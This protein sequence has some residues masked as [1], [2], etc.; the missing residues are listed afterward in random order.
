VLGLG[1]LRLLSRVNGKSRA[2]RAVVG[3]VF[4]LPGESDK[5]QPAASV[6]DACEIAKNW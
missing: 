2:K 4:D 5:E 3:E 1:G 6:S